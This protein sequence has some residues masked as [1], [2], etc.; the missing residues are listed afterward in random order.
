MTWLEDEGVAD[1]VDRFGLVAAGDETGCDVERA[2]H[3]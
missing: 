1:P 3:G 2:K